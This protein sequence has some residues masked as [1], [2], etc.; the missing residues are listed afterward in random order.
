[1]N[2]PI[3]ETTSATSKLRN[4]GTRRGR[5]K[6]DES[7]VLNSQPPRKPMT[8]KGE[9]SWLEPTTADGREG[10]SEPSRAAHRG[11]TNTVVPTST[12]RQIVDVER[13]VSL[14]LPEAPM[15]SRKQ[16]A[17]GAC[18][19][20]PARSERACRALARPA[21]SLSPPA[22]VKDARF[23]SW[24]SHQCR[25]TETP[26]AASVRGGWRPPAA[27]YVHPRRCRLLL[28]PASNPASFPKR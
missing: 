12:T 15:Y 23:P 26:C 10:G 22:L 28:G 7:R 25:V 14:S 19:A 2:V 24:L 9:S 27:Y 11:G 17:S 4:V 5:H 8:V 1:M 21:L 13:T 3:S 6:F 16:F 20:L 18:E